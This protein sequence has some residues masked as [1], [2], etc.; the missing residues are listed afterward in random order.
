MLFLL[1]STIGVLVVLAALVR[2]PKRPVDFTS[3]R[4][5]DARP[6]GGAHVELVV[7]G[8]MYL[9]RVVNEDDIRARA[10]GIAPLDTSGPCR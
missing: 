3:R 8:R 6:A 7:A 10:W 4:A 1:I 9:Y 5:A 2:T